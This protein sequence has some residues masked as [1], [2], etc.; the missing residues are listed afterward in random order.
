MWDRM[1][2]RMLRD[3]VRTG[4]LTVVYPHGRTRTY[5]PGPMW[6]ITTTCRA[7][8]TTCFSTPTGSIPAPISATRHDAGRGAGAKKHHIARKL[9]IEPGMRVLDIGCGWG[10]MG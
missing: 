9:L 10:G 4:A 8:F 6:R 5:G 1:L 7:S 3:F 2:D